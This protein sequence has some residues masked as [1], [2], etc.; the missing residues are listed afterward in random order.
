MKDEFFK[1]FRHAILTTSRTANTGI[2][3][4][5]DRPGKPATHVEPASLI[6]QVDCNIRQSARFI[7]E[8]RE[9]TL[10]L[11]EL[12]KFEQQLFTIVSRGI[13]T[14]D[15]YRT[16]PTGAHYGIRHELIPVQM[17]KL[18]NWIVRECDIVSEPIR[19]AAML[20]YQLDFILHPY[21]DACGR[22]TRSLGAYF[23]L[24]HGLM[25]PRFTLREDYY[26]QMN[27]SPDAFC[28]YYAKC[29]GET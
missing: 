16:S 29:M 24:R 12:F 9:S 21:P 26:K 25:P 10:S 3:S 15:I 18:R 17:Q 14:Q 8:H 13:N 1:R 23:L 28:M 4:G 5:S 7:W 27:T 6:K 22:M 20:E 11:T 19:F 2:I